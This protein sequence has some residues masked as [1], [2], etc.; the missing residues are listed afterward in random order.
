M[1]TI[2]IKGAERSVSWSILQLLTKEIAD[3]QIKQESFSAVRRDESSPHNPSFHSKKHSL[4]FSVTKHTARILSIERPRRPGTSPSLPTVDPNIL[5][6]SSAIFISKERA[7]CAGTLALANAHTG[8]VGRK[9]G[10]CAFDVGAI[11]LGSVASA[12]VACIDVEGV[13]GG[14]CGD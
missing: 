13:G 3:A 8:N 10:A 6:R 11:A 2:T 9:I 12:V 5:R 4:P 7:M 1:S 14:H